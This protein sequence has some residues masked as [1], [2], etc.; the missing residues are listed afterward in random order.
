MKSY[1][2]NMFGILQD[3]SSTLHTSTVAT[4]SYVLNS[5]PANMGHH[6]KYVDVLMENKAAV[7]NHTTGAE[8]LF[9]VYRIYNVGRFCSHIPAEQR[10]YPDTLSAS[11][12]VRTAPTRNY[13]LAPPKLPAKKVTLSRIYDQGAATLSHNAAIFVSV[14][15]RCVRDRGGMAGGL[16]KAP[17][18]GA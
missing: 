5:Y 7:C 16:V 9:W 18:Q 12:A 11:V 6:S 1:A 3:S 2:S 10:I 13:I 15:I 4:S 8:S 14:A 17:D